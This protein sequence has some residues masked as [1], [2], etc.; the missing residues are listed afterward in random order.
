M[1]ER[2]ENEKQTNDLIQRILAVLEK[3][4]PVFHHFHSVL[5][6]TTATP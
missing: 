5:S 6:K 3:T 1:N 2:L 4:P